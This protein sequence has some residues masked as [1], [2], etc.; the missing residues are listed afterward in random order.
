[1]I[2]SSVAP[3]AIPLESKGCEVGDVVFNG[4]VTPMPEVGLPCAQ[5]APK[6]TDQMNAAN[7]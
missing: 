3:S 4:D 2:L 5:A 7:M 1:M 6:L